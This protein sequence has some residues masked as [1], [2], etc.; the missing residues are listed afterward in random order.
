[1]HLNIAELNKKLSNFQISHALYDVGGEC[2]RN[3]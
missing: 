2:R 1:M 3:M